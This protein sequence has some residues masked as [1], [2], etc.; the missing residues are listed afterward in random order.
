MST[1]K[2]TSSKTPALLNAEQIAARR[3]PFEHAEINLAKTAN[4]HCHYCNKRFSSEN[5]FMKHFCEPRRRAEEM[6]SPV[7]VSAYSLYREWMRQKRF[8]QPSSAAF[9]ESKYY[10][11]FIN[12][13]QLVAD[14]NIL[15]PER[16]IQLMVE[17]EIL[18]VLWCRD[19]AYA[20]YIDWA[21]KISDPIDQVQISINV[22]FDICDKENYN[23]EEVFQKIGV[24]RVLSL[25]RQRVLTPWLLFCSPT[26]GAFLKTC[27]ASALK[28]FNGIVN[29]SYWSERFSKDRQ[30]V[31]QVKLLVKE[32]GL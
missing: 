23:I 14:A 12:F 21:D 7:G 26:F 30:T 16:Y 5:I 15:K 2:N 18:P 25:I 29:A 31:E 22:L 20:L 24:Q 32:V 4:W 10:R 1:S 19:A 17:N 11:S 8:T 9:V 27:D 6:L 13:A 3:V 28:A